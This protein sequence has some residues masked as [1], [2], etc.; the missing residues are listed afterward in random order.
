MAHDRHRKG[1]A[2][3][4]LHLPAQLNTGCDLL[5]GAASLQGRAQEEVF[6][7]SGTP[8]VHCTYYFTNAG[9]PLLGDVFCEAGKVADRVQLAHLLSNQSHK[10]MIERAHCTHIARL[11]EAGDIDIDLTAKLWASLPDYMYAE[12]QL[13]CSGNRS[14]HATTL[15]T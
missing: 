15:P 13:S 14:H 10:L 3:K 12:A 9:R 2:D 1:T 11:A 5:A 7:Q 4:L 8:Q 6:Y